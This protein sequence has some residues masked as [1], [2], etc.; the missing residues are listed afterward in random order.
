MYLYNFFFRFK[1]VEY[2]ILSDLLQNKHSLISEILKQDEDK[3]SRREDE[4]NE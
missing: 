4:N 3:I 1:V 2:G